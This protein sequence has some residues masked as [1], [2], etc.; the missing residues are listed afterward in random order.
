LFTKWLFSSFNGLAARRTRLMGLTLG[1]L[2]G[3]M[4]A[5]GSA[6]AWSRTILDLDTSNQPVA[7]HDWGDYWVD[8]SGKRTPEQ[9]AGEAGARWTSTHTD[10]SYP[11]TSGQSV[12]VRFTVPPAPDA[13]RWYLEVPNPAIDRAALYTLDNIGQWTAQQ[14]G[15]LV[16]VS[17]WPVPNR[18]PLLPIALSA[19]VPTYYLLRL[20][21]AH[22]FST[23]LR[24][25][26]ESRL[27][28]SEQRVSLILG[29]FFGLTGLAALMSALSALSLRDPAYGLYA[30]FITLMA[31]TQAT[32][33]GIAGLHL[34]PQSP[35]WNDLSTSVLPLLT[36][37]AALLFISVTV[38]LPTRSRRLHGVALGMA[39]MG[40]L[41]SAALALAPAAARMAVLMPS[42]LLLASSSMLVLAWAWRRGDRFA[43]WLILAYLPIVLA[44]S[45]TL[46][47]N[48][49]LLPTGFWALHGMQLATALHIPFVLV[50]LMLR[51]QQRRENTRRIQGLDRVD[52]GTGLIN[53]HVFASRLLRMVARS[54]RLRH[55]SA[56][57]LI[58]LMNTDQILYKYGR[59][60]AEELPLRLAERLL[61]TARE[62]DSAARLSERRFGMLVEGPFNAEDAA[63]LGPRIVARCLMPY[64][65]MHMDC[66][67]QVHVA[68]AM[69][70]F[71]DTDPQGLLEK[72][73]QLLAAVPAQSKR[74]VFKL[75]ERTKAASFV[76]TQAPTPPSP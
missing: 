37:S 68:Y 61:S 18:H 34:W 41:M 2:L 12:W 43:P 3:T 14:A 64:K 35:W 74:A 30:V 4:L 32:V 20:E 55:Q 49:E 48:T 5:L 62:I 52:P 10:A 76:Q 53:G 33:T 40:I 63:T 69:V 66:V 60:A 23:P 50:E 17:Q 72:L 13:E 1:L 54:R 7:L 29:L 8:T 38:A 65:G 70:P 39:L 46:V 21:N 44:A 27:S 71:Q 31:L 11:V 24:F 22:T 36:A 73:A 19:E 59:N 15:D 9:V 42:L 56:V 51:S 47:S 16:A 45:L 25:I 26:S 75:G 6:K 57:M 67:A 58:D 28:K